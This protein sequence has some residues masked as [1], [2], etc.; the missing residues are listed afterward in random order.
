MKTIT[1]KGTFTGSVNKSVS[2]EV[3]RPNG[4]PNPYDFRKK[5][6]DDF[7]ENFV[8]LED[9][10]IYNIDFSG[11]TTGTFDLEISGE[12]SAPNP[13]TDSF[14]AQAFSP[15]YVIQTN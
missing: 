8:D 12:F 5:Y 9:G 15:G 6:F 14:S 11:F 10:A 4:L 13:I 3:Y 1:I 7:S 2:V